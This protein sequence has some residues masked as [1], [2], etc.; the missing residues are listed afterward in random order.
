MDSEMIGR[1]AAIPE[2]TPVPRITPSDHW[3]VRG[4]AGRRRVTY[5][6]RATRVSSVPPTGTGA[7]PHGQTETSSPTVSVAPTSAAPAST[8]R[9]RTVVPVRSTDAVPTRSTGHTSRS[10]PAT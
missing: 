6:V 9:S 5:E 10:N 1:A 7:R 4:S 3:T 2:M 8:S